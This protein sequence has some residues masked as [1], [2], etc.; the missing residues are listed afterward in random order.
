M[1]AELISIKFIILYI[2]ILSTLFIHYRGKVRFKFLRQLTDH[3]T[4]MAP[5]NAFIYLFSAVPNTRYLDNKY[6]PELKVLQDNW[7][8][9]REE[10][11]QLLAQQEI[12]ASDKYD[13][14]GFNS[15][16]RTGWKRFY[17]KWYQGAIPSAEKL[18][19]KTSA[20]INSIPSI[21]G[22]MFA[23]LPKGARLGKHRD[24]YA[25]SLRFHLGIITPNSDDCFISVDGEH[26]S[27]R[28]GEYVL[29]DETYIHSAENKSEL[30][31]LVLFCDVARP[32]RNG[33]ATA[34][35]NFFNK[36][37]MVAGAA[38]NMEGDYVGF[39]NRIFKYVFQI[40]IY[41]KRLKKKNR[42][43]YRACKYAV[44]AALVYLIFFRTIHF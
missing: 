34:I 1:L 38:K 33:I 15:F 28:D 18:C 21:N 6:F 11:Q 43:L 44:V 22:A 40:R 23:F 37:L 17:I 4:F 9:V 16:F 3:S 8:I 13:D 12:K 41:S 32:M 26:Y 31:R 20:L 5:I 2:F 29:F 27:W 42:K 10:A 19:P 36:T 25:G 7:K 14:T 30:D 35:N 39:F 24:P